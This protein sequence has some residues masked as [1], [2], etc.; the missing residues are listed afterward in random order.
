MA[1]YLTLSCRT[2]GDGCKKSSN[3]CHGTDQNA[4]VDKSVVTSVLKYCYVYHTT[5]D[6]LQENIT[7]P[8]DTTP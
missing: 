2:S 7:E 8:E 5:Q 4:Q 3:A 1:E 6:G